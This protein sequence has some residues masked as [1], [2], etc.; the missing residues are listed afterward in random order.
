MTRAKALLIIVG[1]PAIIS[2][3]EYWKALYNYCKEHGSCVCFDNCP[4]SPDMISM[5][6]R[7]YFFSGR[8]A[9]VSNKISVSFETHN[10][11]KEYKMETLTNVLVC[12][13][14]E[15]LTLTE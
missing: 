3:D 6:K 1:N 7:E 10:L 4:L 14:K 11:E 15:N 8:S 12:G 5:L 13:I 9:A 2:T